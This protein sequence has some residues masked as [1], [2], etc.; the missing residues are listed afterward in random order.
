MTKALDRD[1]GEFRLDDGRHLFRH[2]EHLVIVG[3]QPISAGLIQGNDQR[4][5]IE[6]GQAPVDGLEMGNVHIGR[7]EVG[8][9]VDQWD[10]EV[11][12]Q[13]QAHPGHWRDHAATDDSVNC[14]S[15]SIAS[16]IAR[17]G[18]SYIAAI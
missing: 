14:R 4:T 16:R 6:I 8:D 10:R 3:Y 2:I 17:T 9:G 11:L 7:Q 5:V 1:D 13:R 18:S 12:I 15:R